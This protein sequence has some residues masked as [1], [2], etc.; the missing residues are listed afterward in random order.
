MFTHFKSVETKAAVSNSV[1]DSVSDLEK[2]DQYIPKLL[3]CVILHVTTE[4]RKRLKTNV[5]IHACLLKHP[6]VG[7][8]FFI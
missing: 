1:K 3:L 4:T 5:K 8:F 7:K 6:F 2:L